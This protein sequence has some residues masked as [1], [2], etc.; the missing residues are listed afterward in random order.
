M[1]CKNCKQCLFDE[2][3]DDMKVA[4]IVAPIILAVT[5]G[6]Y[7][8]FRWLLPPELWDRVLKILEW[9]F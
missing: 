9:A 5:V 6:L 1:K 2:V 7:Y 8:L 4:L 3:A